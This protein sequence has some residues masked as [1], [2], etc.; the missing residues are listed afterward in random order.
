MDQPGRSIV[1]NP[2]LFLFDEPGEALDSGNKAVMAD[3]LQAASRALDK[4]GTTIVVTRD[5]E[6][7]DACENNI[8]L[9]N[10]K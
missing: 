2:K 8:E 3:S 10:R 6:I 7:I 5:Q 9:G 4:S 1:R